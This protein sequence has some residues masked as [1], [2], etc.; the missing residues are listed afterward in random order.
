MHDKVIFSQEEEWYDFN[1]AEKK[2]LRRSWKTL[3]TDVKTISCN[4]YTMI[5]NQCPDVRRLFPFMRLPSTDNEKKSK[6]FVFQALRFIQVLETG[7]NSLDNLE[8]FDPILDNL[9]RRHGKLESSH[10]FRPYY[11][12]IFLECT[13]HHIR[14]AL[15]NS[16]VD[17]WNNKDA[18]N[19]II[20]WRHLVSGIC[21]RIK[22]TIHHIRL[23]LI[24]SKVD[25]LNNKDADNAIILW[26][27]LVSGICQ[28]IM[29]MQI[30]QSYQTGTL[31]A[32]YGREWSISKSASDNYWVHL[33]I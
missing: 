25:H 23:A 7:I 33:E 22:C 5:F 21:Q 15:I 6:E 12:S 32:L 18:D 4:I 24:N 14:L 17:H 13:I 1:E 2:I 16:K 30:I 27:H 11:W 20:L 10:G 9:G 3:Q 8:S 28:R 26:R 31:P 19:A 29:M